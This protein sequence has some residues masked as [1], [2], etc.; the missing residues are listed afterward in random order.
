MYTNGEY[1]LTA[2]TQ[3][4]LVQHYVVVQ[5]TKY[6]H[7]YLVCVCVRGI[8][9]KVGERCADQIR[10]LGVGIGVPELSECKVARS[11]T[12]TVL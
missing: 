7:V 6:M 2:A 10:Q 8:P 9:I 5:H 1:L 11:R 3:L 12:Q 4:L